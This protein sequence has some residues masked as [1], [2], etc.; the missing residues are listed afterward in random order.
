MGE[1]DGRVAIVTG[2]NRGIGFAVAE[3]LVDRGAAVALVSREAETGRVA[4]LQLQGRGGAKVSWHGGDT[5]RFADMQAV[6]S[7]VLAEHGRIDLLVGSGSPRRPGPML[8]LETDPED[9]AGYFVRQAVTR[10]NIL[11]ACTD[12]MISRGKGKVVFLT[13]DAGRV[14]TPSEALLGAGAAG[15][16]FAT[17]A[18]ARE[19][20]RYGIRINAVSTTLTRETP[21]FERFTD[22]KNA[23]LVITR[24]FKKIEDRSAFGLNSPDD[25]AAAVLYF[26]SDVSDQV[27]G[28]TLSVNGGLSFPG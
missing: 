14:P 18:L 7:E 8:F 17:R 4:A 10:L 23:D 13:T 11:R 24:A 25:V 9:Y 15:L 2:G 3:G 19:L 6:V 5:T 28:A 21:A 16:M 12:A 26:L 22:A 27:S 20:G 1:H